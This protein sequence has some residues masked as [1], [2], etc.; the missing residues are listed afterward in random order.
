MKAKNTTEN[1]CDSCAFDIPTC[2]DG[3][4]EFGDGI[5]IGNDNVISCDLYVSDEGVKEVAKSSDSKISEQTKA[6]IDSMSYEGLLS[7][8]RNAPVGHPYFQGEVGDYYKK[9][10]FEK[11]DQI[12]HD[13]AVQT[14]KKIGWT[15]KE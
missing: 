12:G 6:N 8:W 4:I 7:L 3:N 13:A 1:L 15:G 10:M 14:S 9:V 5:G 2:G 11:R